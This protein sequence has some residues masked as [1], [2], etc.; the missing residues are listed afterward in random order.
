MRDLIRRSLNGVLNGVSPP[1]CPGENVR[2]SRPG[3]VSGAVWRALQF[4]E[5]PF[6]SDCGAPYATP[7]VLGGFCREC[8]D[9]PIGVDS[10]RAAVVY[11][12]M[13]HRL[14]VA[15]K[16]GDR[17]DLAPT[18]AGWV[19]RAASGVIDGE[20]LI[21]PVPLHPKR[22]H[23]RRYNQSALIARHVAKSAGARWAPDLLVRR[24]HTPPQ[25]SL[26]ASQRRRNVAGAIAVRESRQ[27]IV[28]GARIALVDDVLTTGATIGACAKALRR[29]G[30]AKLYAVVAAR[31]VRDGKEAI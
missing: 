11:N 27:S 10:V 4:I 28:A 25:Q 7:P 30:A 23:M 31:V 6:C 16:H 20:T 9:A 1:L 24:R 8:P 13:A 2:V 29:A 22:L 12:D 26:S 5:D 19:T 14:I 17:T 3:E 18:I 15:F 21:V